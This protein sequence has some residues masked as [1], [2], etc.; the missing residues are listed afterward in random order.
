MSERRERLLF[1]FHCSDALQN[2][3]NAR[4]WEPLGNRVGLLSVF[5]VLT[6][7]A[8]PDSEPPPGFFVT[9][10]ATSRS[11]H[12]R[13]VSGLLGL[14]QESPTRGI[15]GRSFRQSLRSDPLQSLRWVPAGSPV[16][17]LVRLRRN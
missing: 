11:H 2:E 7:V 6:L 3:T 13:F 15:P 8:E 16:R 4:N 17:L 5:T 1:L 14:R 10:H 12:V 9:T